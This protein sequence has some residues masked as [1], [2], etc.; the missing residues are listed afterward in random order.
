MNRNMSDAQ[1]LLDSIQEQEEGKKIVTLK[2]I[3]GGNNEGMNWLLALEEKTAFLVKELHPGKNMPRYL[4]VQ[5]YLVKKFSDRS[6]LLVN[7]TNGDNYGFVDPAMFILE[8]RLH[9]ILYDPTTMPAIE[10]DAVK[11][12]KE[13]DKNSKPETD[14]GEASNRD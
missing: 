3:D 12:E 1:V 10:A 2:L 9:E 4:L 11:E 13:N 14:L 5:Y 8:Y 7:Q 6:V